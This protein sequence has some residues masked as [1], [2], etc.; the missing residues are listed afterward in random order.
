MDHYYYSWILLLWIT[1]TIITIIIDHYYYYYYYY[2]ILKFCYPKILWV[3]GSVV[4][5]HGDP[6]ASGV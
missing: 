3:P 2:W 5:P 1:I 6:L 4:N